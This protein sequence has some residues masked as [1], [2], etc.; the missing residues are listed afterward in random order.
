MPARGA[1]AE[2]PGGLRW[3]APERELQ[4]AHGPLLAAVDEVGRGPLAGP[5][6]VCAI[7]MP[8]NAPEVAGVDDSK[9]LSAAARERAAAAVRAAA[10]AYGLGAASAR[11]VD[12]LNVYRAT[13]LAMRRGL[14]ALGRRLAARGLGP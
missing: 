4:R 12:A 9:R 3:S 2:P 7:V 1:R 6:V 5:V 10:V 8:P 11:E 13:V 14:T